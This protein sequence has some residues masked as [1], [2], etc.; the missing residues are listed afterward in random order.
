MLSTA[1][2][3]AACAIPTIATVPR[4]RS[5]LGTLRGTP[6]ICTHHTHTLWLNYSSRT[7]FY[8]PFYS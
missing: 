4:S 5:P 2:V 7:W 8:A 3:Q 6:I 1:A